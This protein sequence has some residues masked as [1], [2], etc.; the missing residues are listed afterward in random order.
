M[1]KFV[2][3][4]LMICLVVF[5]LYHVVAKPTQAAHDARGW[6]DGLHTVA[7]SLA[8]FVDSF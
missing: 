2:P 5:V 4:I 7:S 3:R 1:M 8:T 6:L